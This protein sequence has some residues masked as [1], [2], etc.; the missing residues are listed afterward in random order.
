[1]VETIVALAKR[2][3]VETIAE[4]VSSARILEVVTSLGVDYAQG[5]HLG[6]P[7]PIE[8]YIEGVLLH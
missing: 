7:E 3:H 5:Y 2:L 4:Y 6:K 1:M 8:E